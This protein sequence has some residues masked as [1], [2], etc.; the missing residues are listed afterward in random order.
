[1]LRHF[2]NPPNWFTS[3]SLFC[4][5]YAIVVATGVEGE[6]NFYRAASLILFA[7]VFDA[8]DG[9]VA[10]L[11]GTGSRFGVELDSLADTVS[12]GIAPAV[13]LYAWGIHVLGVL[14][15]IGAFL[16]AL[17]GVFR[18]ARFN[19]EATGEKGETTKGLTITAAGVTV[20]AAVMAHAA[21]GRTSV[22]HPV[23]VL[24]LALVLGLLMVSAI[25][26]RTFRAFRQGGVVWLALTLGAV[27]AVAVRYRVQTA[28]IALAGVYVV[29]GPLERLVRLRRREAGLP[30]GSDFGLADL[31]EVDD[32]AEAEPPGEAG[33][34]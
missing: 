19:L 30:G 28:P 7:A 4:G 31:D 6:P 27:I 21:S 10:R 24:V 2:L 13:L 16:F 11:T 18:L 23:N 32:L 5:L 29:S 8:V 34:S 20:A 15:L 1:M 12:F 14:G 26:Y 17:C 33:R 3:A 22:E 25:P 9:G